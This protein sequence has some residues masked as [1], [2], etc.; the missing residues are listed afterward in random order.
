M[1]SLV[2]YC[3]VF[4]VIFYCSISL[5]RRNSTTAIIN[6]LFLCYFQPFIFSFIRSGR[7]PSALSHI[8]CSIYFNCWS[9]LG[10]VCYT[11]TLLHLWNSAWARGLSN[12]KCICRWIC[13]AWASIWHWTAIKKVIVSTA[14]DLFILHLCPRA[15]PLPAAAHLRVVSPIP[16]RW[17]IHTLFKQGQQHLLL[18]PKS[19]VLDNYP[20][21]IIPPK[22]IITSM[23]FNILL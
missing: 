9:V 16:P 15:I 6:A 18:P 19:A 7:N 10:T 13:H 21:F 3:R 8:K 20:I 11:P 22:G 14:G 12:N 17:S 23:R 5:L 4:S 1:A 2:L